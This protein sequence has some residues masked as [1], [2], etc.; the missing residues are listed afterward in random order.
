L[1]VSIYLA[2]KPERGL[3]LVQIEVQENHG[4]GALEQGFEF[5]MERE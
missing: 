2:S 3:E 4:S 5:H 1:I